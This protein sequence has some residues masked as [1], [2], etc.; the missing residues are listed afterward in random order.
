[1]NGE[2]RN[3]HSASAVKRSVRF[4]AFGRSRSVLV[5]A[6]CIVLARSTMGPGDVPQSAIV[7]VG[8]AEVRMPE[9]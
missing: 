2:L 6:V 4:G 7:A 5:T 9:Q 3:R 8:D 1:M